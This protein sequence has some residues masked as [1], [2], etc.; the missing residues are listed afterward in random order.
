MKVAHS[1][2]VIAVTHL[3]IACKCVAN[4]SKL[5]LKLEVAV[6]KRFLMGHSTLKVL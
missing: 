1:Q 2:T 6:V 4:V 3:L 5:C